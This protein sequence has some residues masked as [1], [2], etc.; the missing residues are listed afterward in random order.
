MSI[1]KRPVKVLTVGSPAPAQMVYSMPH[2]CND[3]EGERPRLVLD[4]SKIGKMNRAAMG[5]LLAYL[6]EA[7]KHNGDVRLAS[8]HPEAAATLHLAGATRLFEIYDTPESAIASFH[9]RPV[10]MARMGFQEE[11]LGLDAQYA[12]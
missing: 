6:E 12:A 9:R 10:S 3:A 7:M 4:C 1:N 8:V 2:L 5:V 11:A